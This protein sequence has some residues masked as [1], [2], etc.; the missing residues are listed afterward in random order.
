[1]AAPLR[2]TAVVVAGILA[3]CCLV[4]LNVNDETI[5]AEAAV[6]TEH[7]GMMFEH[8]EEEDS[9]DLSE[10]DRQLIAAADIDDDQVQT[11]KYS[12]LRG[13]KNTADKKKTSDQEDAED[14]LSKEDNDLIHAAN[15][16]PTNA[17]WDR[18]KAKKAHRAVPVKVK[19]QPEDLEET[20]VA[21]PHFTAHKL[22]A[23]DDDL[24]PE[25][26]ALIHAAANN[27]HKAL[28]HKYMMRHEKQHTY[29][30]AVHRA[31]VHKLAVPTPVR[32]AEPVQIS[33]VSK[34]QSEIATS[35]A[36]K[37]KQAHE[38]K[39]AR[40]PAHV[41]HM[42][43]AKKPKHQMSDGE[44]KLRQTDDDLTPEERKLINAA[45]H[46]DPQKLRRGR[47]QRHLEDPS[48]DMIEEKL[49]PGPAT[50][51]MRR[52][53]QAARPGLDNKAVMRKAMEKITKSAAQKAVMAATTTLPELHTSDLLHKTAPVAKAAAPKI[54][55]YDAKKMSSARA[56]VYGTKANLGKL[57]QHLVDPADKLE[58]SESSFK[59]VADA[60]AVQAKALKA[61]FHRLEAESSKTSED[62]WQHQLEAADQ[63]AALMA[64]HQ[65]VPTSPLQIARAAMM[66]RKMAAQYRQSTTAAALPPF[67]PETTHSMDA[68]AFIMSHP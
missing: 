43:F 46:E 40:K 39:L 68:H 5:R 28:P 64:R 18:K 36:L 31:A 24:S 22:G 44:K 9:D 56:I 4:T 35:I 30:P 59:T 19:T 50:R 65:A 6:A 41:K 60:R 34:M 45:S 32:K 3:V 58:P 67:D 63:R 2:I 26:E 38:A 27:N 25:D 37:M 49:R 1:M 14:M 62:S 52:P 23:S 66:R 57:Q 55:S 10:V 12:Q 11:V 15:A 21:K 33:S 48:L 51:P 61:K 8:E 7:G 47:L 16:V 13:V 42:D 54:P 53:T 29:K 17:P 20:E